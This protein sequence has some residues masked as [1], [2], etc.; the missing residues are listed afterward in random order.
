MV[1][2]SNECFYNLFDALY[3]NFNLDQVLECLN[4]CKN[5]GIVV[6]FILL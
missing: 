5:V 4:K 3:L 6:K 2:K 1:D